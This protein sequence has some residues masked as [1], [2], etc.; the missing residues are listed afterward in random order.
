MRTSVILGSSTNYYSHLIPA[1]CLKKKKKNQ[2]NIS[3]ILDDQYLCNMYLLH[4]L[5]ERIF[6]MKRKLTAVN[7]CKW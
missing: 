4:F 5:K 6:F 1:I 3:V 7:N 2:V